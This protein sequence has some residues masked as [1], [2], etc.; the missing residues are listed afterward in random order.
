M[1]QASTPPKRRG[2]GRPRGGASDARERI[3]TAAAAEFSARGY[4]AATMR[5]IADRAG[6]DAALVHHY[7]GTKSALFAATVD[8]PVDPAQLIG[9]ALEGDLDSAGE[10][11]VR[12]IVTLWDSPTFRPRGVA[13]LRGVIGSRRTSSMLVGFVSREILDRI[14]ARLG[15]G[16]DASR[17]TSLVASQIV[18]LIVAR[19][20]LKLEPVAS[21]SVDELATD[22][23]PTIQRYLT[24]PLAPPPTLES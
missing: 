3:L 1:S 9:T 8:V 12:F 16:P 4:D 23:G 24:G 10:R 21:A 20:V 7:F 14:G 11:L 2:R 15:G 18:G 17:R 19:Y 22:I 13:L 5:A 6:V